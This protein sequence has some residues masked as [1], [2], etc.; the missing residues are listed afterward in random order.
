[1]YLLSYDI[2]I[3]NNTIHMWGY[4]HI[5]LELELEKTHLKIPINGQHSS[6]CTPN[7][8]IGME[9]GDFDSVPVD[10]WMS[11]DVPNI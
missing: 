2:A 10:L 11:L 3:Y 4:Y 5:L 7:M 6:V 8:L 1:M 9:E